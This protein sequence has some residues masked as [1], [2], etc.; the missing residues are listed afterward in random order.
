VN[1]L[2]LAPDQ[3]AC[4]KCFGKKSYDGG[5]CF[6]CMSAG[7]VPIE[8]CKPNSREVRAEPRKPN[9]RELGLAALRRIYGLDGCE[10]ERRHAR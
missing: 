3:A 1:A 4:P 5:P 7:W 9:P 8:L 2:K 6:Y 10:S